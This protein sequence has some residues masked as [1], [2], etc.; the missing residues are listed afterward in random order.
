MI[1]ICIKPRGEFNW[2]SVPETYEGKFIDDFCIKCNLLYI[3][4]E[5]NE[6]DASFDVSVTQDNGYLHGSSFHWST[7][8]VSHIEHCRWEGH[9]ILNEEDVCAELDEREL[10]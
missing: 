8:E 7:R 9:S 1:T 4:V 5:P 3:E 6:I 2:S 10:A